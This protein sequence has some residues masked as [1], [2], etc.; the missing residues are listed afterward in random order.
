MAKRALSVPARKLQLRQTQ[1]G[2]FGLRC[3]WI[4]DYY[5]LVVALRIRR[6]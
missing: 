5:V 2:I 3:E 6:I 4:V 1:Q